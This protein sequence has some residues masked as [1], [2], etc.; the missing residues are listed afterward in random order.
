M[1]KT[2]LNF[3]HYMNFE[4]YSELLTLVFK[5]IIYLNCNKCSIAVI[6]FFEIISSESLSDLIQNDQLLTFIILL[7]TSLISFVRGIFKI[8]VDKV[9]KGNKLEHLIH[10]LNKN[11]P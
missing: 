11:V 5:N 7:Q 9:Q 4:K 6:S 3:G 2:K 10:S 1:S 8:F